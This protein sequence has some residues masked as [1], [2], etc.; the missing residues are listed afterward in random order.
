MVIWILQLLW[1]YGE[2][3]YCVSSPSP[4][5]QT[6]FSG[7]EKKNDWQ[8]KKKTHII[9]VELIWTLW[10]PVLEV[11]GFRLAYF[12]H[13]L[14]NLRKDAYYSKSVPFSVKWDRKEFPLGAVLRSKW[15]V[16]G[17]Y[18]KYSLSANY[19]MDTQKM[20]P[21]EYN[22]S[23]HLSLVS[24]GP[25]TEDVRRHILAPLVISLCF[26]KWPSYFISEGDPPWPW[27]LE[28]ATIF[29]TFSM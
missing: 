22:I 28:S 3:Q 21:M 10:K 14:C 13:H 23:T 20:L 2:L 15:N 27:F 24:I 16:L 7:Q 19:V 29:S 8:W 17:M 12:L 11:D 6:Y 26:I 18:V 25:G 9:E 4:I 1:S 5:S